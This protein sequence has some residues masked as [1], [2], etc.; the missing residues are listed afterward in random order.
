MHACKNMAHN[1]TDK[2]R[3]ARLERRSK[4]ETSVYT[5][6]SL[7]AFIGTAGRLFEIPLPLRRSKPSHLSVKH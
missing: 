5:K 2:I 1:A 6:L 7:D 4:Y 3:S